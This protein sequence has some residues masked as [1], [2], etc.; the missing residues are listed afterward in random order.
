MTHKRTFFVAILLGFFAA[1]STAAHGEVQAQD[2]QACQWINRQ[3]D[4][5]GAHTLSADYSCGFL[6]GD[7][8]A[9]GAG[10]MGAVIKLN[11]ASIVT[12]ALVK[13]SYTGTLTV[14]AH[15]QGCDAGTCDISSVLTQARLNPDAGDYYSLIISGI[16]LDDGSELRSVRLSN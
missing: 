16:P 10:A 13:A 15:G 7:W 11:R 3:Y 14:D 5:S 8:L 6:G 9:G 2:G 12:L 4:E 1:S